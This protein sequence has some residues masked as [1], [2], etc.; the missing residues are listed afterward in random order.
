MA[1]RRKPWERLFD[2]V[3]VHRDPKDVYVPPATDA[4]LDD[5]ETQLG[6]QLPHTYRE[7]MKRFGP[8]ELNGWVRFD[9]VTGSK[10]DRGKT[11]AG[12]TDELREFFQE[13]GFDNGEWLSSL[14]FF[15]SSGGGDFYAW[16]PSAVARSRSRE[17]RCHMLPHGHEDR[18]VAVGNRFWQFVTRVE[19][20]TISWADIADGGREG[21][22]YQPLYLRAKKRPRKQDVK[23]WLAWNNDTA[24]SLARTIRENDRPDLFPILAD[25]LEDAGCDNADVLNSCRQGDPEIDGVWVLEVLLGKE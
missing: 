3:K 11:V 8:G 16:D 4:E 23:P 17:C 24:L 19:E 5:L 18:P 21:L 14:V 6:S 13:H 15:A 10:K 22:N 25:A 7:F 9:R 20:D 1:E 12:R 2:T